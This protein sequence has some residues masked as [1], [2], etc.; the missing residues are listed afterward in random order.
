MGV[1]IHVLVAAGRRVQPDVH[2]YVS[3]LMAHQKVLNRGVIRQI[4]GKME[5]GGVCVA[6]PS[7]RRRC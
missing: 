3:V 5:E 2:S 1:N 6:T 4:V 7:R